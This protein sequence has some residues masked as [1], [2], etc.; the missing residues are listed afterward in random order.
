M[1][2]FWIDYSDR[3]NFRSAS[4]KGSSNGRRYQGNEKEC[5]A[6]N[7]GEEHMGNHLPYAPFIE[8]FS[9]SHWQ[10]CQSFSPGLGEANESQDSV[11]VATVNLVVVGGHDDGL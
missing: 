1:Y 2:F 5:K 6:E 9:S 4:N 10:S 7:G 8:F 3:S 11:V